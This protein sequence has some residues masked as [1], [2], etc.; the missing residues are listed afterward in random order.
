MRKPIN[1]LTAY[2]DAK[3]IEHQT[4][5]D[6]CINK[7]LENS[8]IDK[9]ILFQYGIG[10][11]EKFANHPKIRAVANQDRFRFC[12]AINYANKFLVN[13]IAIISNSDIFFDS[14]IS[15]FESIN[16]NNLIIALTRVDYLD[17]EIVE[18]RQVRTLN[19][20]CKTSPESCHDSWA[21]VAPITDFNSDFYLGTMNSDHFFVYNARNGKMRVLNGYKFIKT[22]HVHKNDDRP[23]FTTKLAYPYFP[24]SRLT[25]AQE[26]PYV[27]KIL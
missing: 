1:L 3:D 23:Y 26:L 18:G 7:N 2:Y 6:F 16:F 20:T 13:E 21:F 11:A 9:I 10:L 17:G 27:I 4:E 25:T 22:Y 15:L 19:G 8:S 14:K 12:H 5:I 24:S